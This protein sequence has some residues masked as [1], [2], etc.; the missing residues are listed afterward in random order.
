[1]E[2]CD[3]CPFILLFVELVQIENGLAFFVARVKLVPVCDVFFA[4]L[5]AEERASAVELVREVHKAFV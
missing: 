5:P 4:V 1:M 2:K 3:I